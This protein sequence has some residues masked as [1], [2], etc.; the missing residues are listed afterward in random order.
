MTIMGMTITG[1]GYCAGGVVVH[2][3]LS[4]WHHG[5]GRFEKSEKRDLRLT[6]WLAAAIVI[7]SLQ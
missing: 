4:L 5:A 7:G 2:A 6:V 3:F 1:F